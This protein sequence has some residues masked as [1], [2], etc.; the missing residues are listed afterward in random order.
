LSHV[1][2]LEVPGEKL[3]ITSELALQLTK[4]C[5]HRKMFVSSTVT[6]RSRFI[7]AESQ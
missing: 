5:T 7:S 6:S 4:V 2:G 3:A 1:V